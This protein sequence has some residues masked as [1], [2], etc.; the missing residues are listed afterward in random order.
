MNK[1]TLASA[2][3][4]PALLTFVSAAFFAFAVGVAAQA[5]EAPQ[6]WV[7]AVLHMPDDIDVL[8]DRE[9]GSSLRMF[10]VSTGVDVDELLS[11]WEAALREAGYTI[12]LAEVETLDRVIEF[13]GQD[14]SNAKIAVTPSMV[15][16]RHVIEFDAT[17]P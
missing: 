14:I 16:D 4:A 6:S 17:L 9:I 7:P 5:E 8:T 1:K 10:S 11:E 13:S 3:R 2:T 15:D 12:I